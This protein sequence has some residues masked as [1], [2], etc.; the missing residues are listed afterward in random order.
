M[1]KL[2]DPSILIK[3]ED[4]LIHIEKSFHSLSLIK[5]EDPP[6]YI[7]KKLEDPM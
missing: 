2:E 6:I 5:L 3:L 7:G 4:P 1:R